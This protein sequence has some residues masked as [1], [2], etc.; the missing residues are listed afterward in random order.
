MKRRGIKVVCACGVL[1]LCS[2][3]NLLNQKVQ[4]KTEQEAIDAGYF[5]VS[6]TCDERYYDVVEVPN[7]GM[8]EMDGDSILLPSK[9]KMVTYCKIK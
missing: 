8:V 3:C 6:G 7:E 5:K 4:I 9:E 2:G 1:W